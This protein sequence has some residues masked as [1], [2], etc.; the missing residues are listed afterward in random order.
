M[1]RL[2]APLFVFFASLAFATSGPI[3]RTARPEHP[4]AVAF[5][6]V[7]IA[8]VLLWLFDLRGLLAAVRSLSASARN[9]VGLG[10][11]LLAAHFALFLWGL[12]ATSLPAAIAL[13]SLEPLSVVLAAWAL[14]GDRPRPIETIGVLVATVGGVVVSRGAGA[15]EH[16]LFGDVLVV[17]AVVLY[18]AYVAVVRKTQTQL[19]AHHAA[20]LVYLSAAACLLVALLIAPAR[21][22][23]VIW[24]PPT[25]ALWAILGLA[26]IPTLI[27]HTS[28]Q[29]ASR[30][31]PPSVVALVSPGE[32]LGGI[33]IAALFMGAK[34]TPIEAAGAAI[35][36]LGATIAIAGAALVKRVAAS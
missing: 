23:N 29:T 3:A 34:P 18:G 17:F 13:V 36:V 30:H 14:H 5:G 16:R 1:N 7:L 32:T 24:P 28:V 25:H 9:T 22:G 12:D 6:R 8:G 2:V 31:L 4:L 35:I 26:A 27:G 10:G 11:A 19:A 20:P 21:A 33:A 15:G